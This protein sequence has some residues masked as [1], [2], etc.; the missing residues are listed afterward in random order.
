MTRIDIINRMRASGATYQRIADLLGLTKQRVFQ[1]YKVMHPKI[2][3]NQCEVCGNDG[4]QKDGYI[5][6]QSC[7][8]DVNRLRG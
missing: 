2:A 7:W 3:T 4:Q 6:C 5:L 1:I 8:L